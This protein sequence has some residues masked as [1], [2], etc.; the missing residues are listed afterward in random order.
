MTPVSDTIPEFSLLSR[1]LERCGWE[2]WRSGPL[3]ADASS[4]HKGDGDRGAPGE[5]IAE[6]IGDGALFFQTARGGVRARTRLLRSERGDSL[7]MVDFGDFPLMG[8][9]ELF[10][11][12]LDQSMETRMALGAAWL[13]ASA[14]YVLLI[15]AGRIE[16]Y[17]LPE[18]IQDYQV[19]SAREF[20]DELLPAL[21]ARSAG[22]S[23]DRRAKYEGR[24]P[25]LRHSP[26]ALH[27]SPMEGAQS[28]RGWLAHWSQLLSAK[29]QVAP[30]DCEIF[31]WKLI[32]ML[33]TS[34][35]T[36]KS[37][38]LGGWGLGCEEL[39]GT[40]TLSYDSLNT[41]AELS[42]QLED[43]DLTFSTR[44]FSGDADMHQK[45]LLDLE[46]TSLAEQ[47][48]AELLMHSRIKFEAE[49][50]AWLFTDMDR[51]QEGWRL[52][53][54]GLPPLRKR[55][56]T[57]GWTVFDPL[58]C[59]I[60]RH[61][62]GLALREIDRLAEHWSQY[63]AFLHRRDT[64]DAQAVFSQ[65]DLFSGTPRGI[66]P[67]GHLDDAINFIFSESLRFTSVNPEEK[68][69]VGVVLLLKALSLV[70]RFDW[71]FFGI[72]T[73]DRVWAD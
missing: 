1:E 57:E 60:G 29:L 4:H 70:H 10:P 11:R 39:G 33:Q 59:D 63:D 41:Q 12:F 13:I 66:G 37:E 62:L 18:E 9:E 48:R 5:R 27:P 43:F 23:D 53:V 47:L 69:G 55:I 32:I 26:I 61:G 25:S 45:W 3:G 38:M 30:E 15:S 58:R 56:A 36:G 28:L 52:E 2:L 17:R 71:P 51:E 6:R 14:R 44:A 42:R 16:L 34:R 22:K 35:K 49:T 50:V 67:S 31:L 68:F 7:L 65:P 20:E 24:A 21:A 46:D 73:L 72:D 19:F 64:R 8:H 54:A 40:W